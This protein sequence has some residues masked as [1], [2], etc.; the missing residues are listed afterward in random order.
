MQRC[1][2]ESRSLSAAAVGRQRPKSHHC[3][4]SL[5]S[6]LKVT[7]RIN[8]RN[9][10][11]ANARHKFSEITF[12]RS[13][14]TFLESR[15]VL[16]FFFPEGLLRI[17][18]GVRPTTLH[19]VRTAFVSRVHLKMKRLV[20]WILRSI[21]LPGTGCAVQCLSSCFT[22][23]LLYGTG[24]LLINHAQMPLWDSVIR[25]RW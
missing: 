16:L 10:F 21:R 13:F 18:G 1:Q 11:L 17:W 25:S 6:R 19:T 14:V 9:C 23:L 7:E 4:C 22:L 8:E 20:R 24:F 15:P 5:I 3:S 2:G 12:S